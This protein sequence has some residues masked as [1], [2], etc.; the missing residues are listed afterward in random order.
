[1]LCV[2]GWGPLSTQTAS[3]KE[4]S[5]I[6]FSITGFQLVDVV[7]PL[8]QLNHTITKDLVNASIGRAFTFKMFRGFCCLISRGTRII[9]YNSNSEHISS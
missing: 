1:M 9:F 5:Q 8:E 7:L 3:S 4:I 6:H 2:W